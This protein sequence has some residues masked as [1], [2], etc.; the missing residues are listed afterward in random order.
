MHIFVC[1]KKKPENAFLT[2]NSELLQNHT[3]KQIMPP[4]ITINWLFNDI[5]YLFIA[6]FDCR[7]GVFQQTVVTVDYILN[8]GLRQSFSHGQYCSILP[9]FAF[10]Q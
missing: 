9:Y 5:C 1:E 8:F 7:I 6:F 10:Q 3:E 4:K 2:L